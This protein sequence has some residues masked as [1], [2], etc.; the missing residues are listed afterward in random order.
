MMNYSRSSLWFLTI[1]V[2][3]FTVGIFTS[4]T[5]ADE[6]PHVPRH[7]APNSVTEATPTPG[8]HAHG[9]LEVATEQPQPSVDLIIHPDAIRGWN[10]EIQ[11]QH[12]EFAPSRVN[13]SNTQTEGHAHLYVDGVKVSRLYGNWYYLES[14]PPGQHEITVSLNSNTHN[15]LTVQGQ[16]IQDTEVLVVP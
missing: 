6:E 3:S 2:F 13:Q 12:F 7:H 16:P 14:L 5:L 8:S 15:T 11:T 9:T 4:P 1:A 10:L